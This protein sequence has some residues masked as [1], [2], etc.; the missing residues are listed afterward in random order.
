MFIYGF[1]MDKRDVERVV[2]LHKVWYSGAEQPASLA[3]LADAGMA[4]ALSQQHGETDTSLPSQTISS[5][6]P[7]LSLLLN[8][9]HPQRCAHGS[10]RRM[11]NGGPRCGR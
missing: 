8:R 5:S 10:P 3:L 6:F 11:A 4:T 9:L 1:R 7:T 2:S